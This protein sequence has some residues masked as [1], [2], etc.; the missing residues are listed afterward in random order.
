VAVQCCR[1]M[2]FVNHIFIWQAFVPSGE[3]SPYVRVSFSAVT[4]EEMD[5]ALKRLAEAIK[6]F[7][8]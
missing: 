1:L 2:R 8:N 6:D 3:P 7:N 4:P 5:E